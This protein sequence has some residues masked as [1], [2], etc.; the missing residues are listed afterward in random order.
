MKQTNHNQKGTKS[1]PRKS[2]QLVVT[3][4]GRRPQVTDKNNNLIEMQWVG[5]I[6][7]QVTNKDGSKYFIVE[8]T[9]Q[10]KSV[11]EIPTCDSIAS[12]IITSMTKDPAFRVVDYFVDN[13]LSEFYAANPNLVI[14]AMNIL[15]TTGQIDQYDFDRVFE[16]VKPFNKVDWKLDKDYENYLWEVYQARS[17]NKL[18]GYPPKGERTKEDFR[19]WLLTEPKIYVKQWKGKVQAYGRNFNIQFAVAKRTGRSHRVTKF[20]NYVVGN[21]ISGDRPVIKCM[22]KELDTPKPKYIRGLPEQTDMAAYPS[23]RRIAEN[24]LKARREIE[25]TPD[26]V[27]GDNAMARLLATAENG[28]TL[29]NNW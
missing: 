10:R 8:S 7:R 1:K 25:L 4:K 18:S 23:K 26:E 5:D 6:R 15:M 12:D 20:S 22:Y 13:G 14:D 27:F 2:P 9:W 11:T 16:Q 19:D 28:E 21:R 17:N 3:K 24:R 29:S